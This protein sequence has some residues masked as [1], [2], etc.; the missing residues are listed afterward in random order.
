MKNIFLN[1][2]PM[3]IILSISAYGNSN[4]S[5]GEHP[6]IAEVKKND[7]DKPDTQST[8]HWFED[9]DD[10]FNRAQKEKKNVMVMVEDL[11]CRWCVKMKKGALSD[12]RVQK[13]LQQYILLKI[14]R[15]FDDMESL[16][17][18]KGPIPSFHFFTSKK[19]FIDR[20]AGYYETEDFLGYIKEISEDTF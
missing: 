15:S 10:A 3:L 11:N 5:I 7:I 6:K 4:K 16:P 9:M 19:E 17:G 12:P 2:V 1:I 13:A 8:L 14:D 20:V 18:L